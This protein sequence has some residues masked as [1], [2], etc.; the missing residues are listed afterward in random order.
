[1]K[2]LIETIRLFVILVIFS[3][4]IFGLAALSMQESPNSSGMEY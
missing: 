2:I 3:M 1:M 4:G